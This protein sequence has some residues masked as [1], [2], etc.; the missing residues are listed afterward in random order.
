[1]SGLSLFEK[2]WRQHCISELADGASL[3]HIDRIF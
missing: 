3:I 1:M 2:L